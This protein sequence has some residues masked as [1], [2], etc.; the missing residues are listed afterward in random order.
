LPIVH[1]ASLRGLTVY[2]QW[3]VDDPG[4]NGAFSATAAFRAQLF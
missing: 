1:D 3:V 4:L 2:G